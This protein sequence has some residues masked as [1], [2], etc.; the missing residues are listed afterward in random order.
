LMLFFTGFQRNA[1]ELAQKQI[2]NFG[3]KKLELRTLSAL[4]DEATSIFQNKNNVVEELGRLMHEGWMLKRGLA[5]GVTTAAIDDI[6]EAGRDAGAI[7]G[8]LLGA[9][10]GGFVLF[11]VDREHRAAVR[12][13]LKDLIHVSFSFDEGGRKIVVFEPSELIDARPR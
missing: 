3:N 6:Y 12:E 5:E 7:G 11:V 10:G 2:A 13:R 4:A 8:K 1:P 9:G